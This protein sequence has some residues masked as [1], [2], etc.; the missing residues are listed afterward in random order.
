MMIKETLEV[1]EAKK[2]RSPRGLK[3]PSLP[4]LLE[5]RELH[6]VLSNMTATRHL[7][8]FTFSETKGK[9]QFLKGPG[10]I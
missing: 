4:W 6:A 9:I 2:K 8:L 5:V 3:L 1:R 10:P 7:W